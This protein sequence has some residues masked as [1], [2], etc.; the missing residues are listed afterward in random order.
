L[1]ISQQIDVHLRR[2]LDSTL[3]VQRERFLEGV[4][5]ITIGGLIPEGILQANE[6]CCYQNGDKL[7]RTSDGKEGIKQTSKLAERRIVL[8]MCS[9]CRQARIIGF[10][11]RIQKVSQTH[12]PQ[13]KWVSGSDLLERRR[14]THFLDGR[15]AIVVSGCDSRERL[16]SWMRIQPSLSVVVICSNGG[17]RLTS[18]TGI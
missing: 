18:W 2:L 17:E 7:S 8:G 3:D 15:S 14:A 6:D 1:L 13:G 16:T 9:C 4:H 11:V 5:E 12:R 10:E